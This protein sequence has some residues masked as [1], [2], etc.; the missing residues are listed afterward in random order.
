MSSEDFDSLFQLNCSGHG[1]EHR[2]DLMVKNAAIILLLAGQ[3]SQ[4]EHFHMS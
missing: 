3:T 4:I 1:G 2:R